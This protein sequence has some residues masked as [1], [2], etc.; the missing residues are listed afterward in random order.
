M[1][2]LAIVVGL[3]PDGAVVLDSV[4]SGGAG[5]PGAGRGARGYEEEGRLRWMRKV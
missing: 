5:G 1:N 3:S 4:R 2:I